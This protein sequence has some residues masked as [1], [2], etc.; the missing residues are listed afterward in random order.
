[1][2]SNFIDTL[3]LPL[4]IEIAILGVT[5]SLQLWRWTVN[6]NAK[7]AEASKRIDT[8]IADGNAAIAASNARIDKTIDATNARLD[9]TIAAGNAQ[10][11]AS[12]ARLDATWQKLM[13]M[14]ERYQEQRGK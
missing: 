12:N 13:E 9:A 1:M 4:M 3:N 11:A 8:T 6:S 10:W 14:T 5:I 2:M 7:M